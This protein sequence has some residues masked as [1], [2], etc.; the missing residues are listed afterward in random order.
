MAPA[1]LDTCC[2][3]DKQRDSLVAETMYTDQVFIQCPYIGSLV[4]YT[5]SSST[6]RS[7]LKCSV[8]CHTACIRL[9]LLA[10]HTWTQLS[11]LIA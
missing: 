8:T 6:A 7:N 1:L 3:T 4:I 5:N 11:Q 9:A 10:V 2:M